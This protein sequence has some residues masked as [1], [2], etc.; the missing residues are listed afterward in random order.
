MDGSLSYPSTTSAADDT[1]FTWQVT[2]RLDN[3]SDF[4]TQVA[5]I[6]LSDSRV[7]A[8][9][10]TGT[11]SAGETQSY[12]GLM[13]AGRAP[14]PGIYT[15]VLLERRN[16]SDDWEGVASSSTFV[17][18]EF[19]N[20]TIP[21]EGVELR[22]KVRVRERVEITND[23][24]DTENVTQIVP[25]VY[26]GNV[27]AKNMTITN[28][29]IESLDGDQLTF[30]KD[31]NALYDNGSISASK[32][33]TQRVTTTYSDVSDVDA[34]VEGV[35]SRRVLYTVNNATY[36]TFITQ[37]N[38]TIIN[39]I[40]NVTVVNNTTIDSP[41][42]DVPGGES[43]LW[44]TCN[45]AFERPRG[46]NE[47]NRFYTSDTTRVELRP[48]E[49]RISDFSEDPIQNVSYPYPASEEGVNV[50]EPFDNHTMILYPDRV[51]VTGCVYVVD[52]GQGVELP[53]II[54]NST[55]DRFLNTYYLN[56]EMK[57]GPFGRIN[58]YV[59]PIE[60]KEAVS[61]FTTN[62]RTG[63]VTV[64]ITKADRSLS[65]QFGENV[66]QFTMEKSEGKVVINIQ[67]LQPNREYTLYEDGSPFQREVAGPDGSVTYTKDG[68]WSEHE[69]ALVVGERKEGPQGGQDQLGQLIPEVSL[70]TPAIVFLA[71]LGILLAVAA[72]LYY[73]R[74][75]D[76]TGTI[77]WE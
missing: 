1:N 71:S 5:L 21:T 50:T 11:F 48:N 40:S 63:N 7:T 23:N 17:V 54:G 65:T 53:A 15:V 34:I 14:S 29:N 66:F 39:P 42:I 61:G 38:T 43:V 45:T 75:Q 33:Y 51:F 72:Y 68:G 55:F 41:F 67:N 69:Y 32:R 25:V 4:L 52:G 35:V 47:V 59:N 30:S 60:N 24:G 16:A 44:Q 13:P 18:S 62:P 2:S 9:S 70:S 73:R 64:N 8:D 26:D 76:Q 46:K 49:I 58:K 10:A 22:T 28:E 3:E 77:Q 20:N 27:P 31:V 37:N 56:T 57:V 12:D 36:P 6:N 74:E 19:T